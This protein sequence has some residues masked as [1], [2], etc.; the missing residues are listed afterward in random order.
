[1]PEYLFREGQSQRHQEDRPVDRMEADD[2]FSDQM[3]VSRPQFCKL[4]R[5]VAVRVISDSCDIVG[6]R[7]QPYIY[8]V[9]IVKIYRN[10]P[11][12]GCSGYTQIL[13]PRKKEVVHHFILSRYR[14]DEL[15]MGIDMLDQAI[16]IFAHLEEVCLL[17]RRLNLAPAVR[18]F[19][20][21]KL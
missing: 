9:L 2:I 1:M 15:R 18:T 4:L 14:L 20:V 11:F 3:K 21:Y 6:E 7:V 16:C 12:E 17:L 8:Y 19:A 13:K 10:P 5:A